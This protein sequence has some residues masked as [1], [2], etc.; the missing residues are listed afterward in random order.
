MF[1]ANGVDKDLCQFNKCQKEVVT[2]I[3]MENH[4]NCMKDRKNLST[5]ASGVDKDL[6]Q[7]NGRKVKVGC[8]RKITSEIITL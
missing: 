5:T 1:I 4:M 3:Q 7:Y 6:V 2:E 8:S